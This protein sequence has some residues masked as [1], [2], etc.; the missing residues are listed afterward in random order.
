MKLNILTTI[1]FNIQA[2]G[3]MQA[4]KCPVLIYGKMKI[5]HIGQFHIKCPLKRGI[6]VIGMNECDVPYAHTIFNN[7]G[8]IEIHDKLYINFG[9]KISNEGV[10]I[11]HGNNIIGHGVSFDIKE[12]FEIGHDATVGFM[13]VVTDTN[14]HYILDVS[15]RKVARRSKPIKIGN[16]NWIGSYSHIKK[17]TITPDYTIVASPNALLSKDYSTLDPYTIL[18]GS[19]AKPL[20]VGLRRIYKFKNEQMINAYFSRNPTEEYFLI[21]NDVNLDIFCGL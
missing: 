20:K 7:R 6:V 16:F 3:I 13:S 2:F 10:M 15:A 11:F 19:P 18:G 12:K 8:V 17:G 1:R 14:V 4:L 5:Y 21:K 9:A